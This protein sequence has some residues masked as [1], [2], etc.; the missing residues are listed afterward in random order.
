MKK[1]HGISVCFVIRNGLI[2]GYP[3]WES[4]HSALPIAD[5][6]IISDGDSKDKTSQVIEKFRNQYP[7]KVKIIKANWE[8]EMGGCGEVISI[9]SKKA[10][11]Y[12]KYEW[13]YYLQADEIIHQDNYK[14]IR[15]VANGKYGVLNSVE[16]KFSHFIGS[17]NPL[18]DNSPAYSSAIRMVKNTSSIYLLGDGWTFVGDVKP[19]LP[20]DFIPRPIF[21]LAWV[22]PK[23]IDLK[24]IEQMKIYPNME[25]Y[26]CKGRE[27]AINIH[28]Q[29]GRQMGLPYPDDISSYPNGIER[30]FGL[31]EY[32]L[33][34]DLM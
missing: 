28:K 8:K 27:S 21:H 9:I 5:E 18:P 14:I 11:E 30:L 3:F 32:K 12:C 2:N 20:I 34:F 23:N 26:Q 10:M 31:F 33:P 4:L 29:G 17:W 24:N 25:A 13:I 19:Q 6:F 1:K 7:D 15:E 16:F 22:F